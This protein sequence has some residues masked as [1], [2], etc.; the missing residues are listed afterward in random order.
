VAH[1]NAQNFF[2]GANRAIVPEVIGDGAPIASHGT[3]SIA[4]L[5][6]PRRASTRADDR[7][8]PLVSCI[9]ALEIR[10]RSRYPTPRHAPQPIEHALDVAPADGIDCGERPS[11]PSKLE[12]P[13]SGPDCFCKRSLTRRSSWL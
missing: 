6:H 12:R 13:S 5:L 9:V 11:L 10:K 8:I 3:A 1:L 7:D 4:H 2:S